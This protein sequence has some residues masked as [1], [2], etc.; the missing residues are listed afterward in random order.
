[1]RALVRVTDARD[2]KHQFLNPEHIRAVHEIPTHEIPGGS[3]ITFS[4]GSTLVV[5]EAVNIVVAAI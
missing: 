1:M 3:Q 5:T 2:K 4:D